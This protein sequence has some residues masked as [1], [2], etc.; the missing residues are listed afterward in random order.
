[1]TWAGRQVLVAGVGVTGTAVTRVLLDLGARVVVVDGGDGERQR[2]SAEQLRALGATVRLGDDRTLVDADLVVAT[3]GMRLDHPLF[4]AARAAGVEVVGEPELAWRL[5]GGGVEGAGAA[6][7]LGI[8]GTNGKTTTVGMLEA[9]LRAAGLR[10]VAAGNVGL[11]LVEAVHASTSSGEPS[12]DVLAV[13]MSSQQLAW[14]PSPRFAAGALLNIAEDHLDWHDTMADYLAAKTRIW[15]GGVAI[16]NA[17]DPVVVAALPAGGRTFSLTDH[18]A[19]YALVDGALV[20]TASGVV[21]VRGDE[22]R[23]R[24]PHNIANALAAAALARAHGVPADAVHDALAAFAPGRH[25]NE[26]V[27]TAGGVDY[28]DDSKATNPH[29]AAASLAAYDHVV[30][31]AGGLLKGADVDGLVA[32][33]AGRLRG[34]VLLGR[35]RAAIAAALA[36]HAPDVPVVDVT[37]TDTGAMETAVRRAAELARP[38]DTVLLAPTAASWDIFR[39]YAQRGDLFA[40]AARALAEPA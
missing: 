19:D 27:A 7:W 34:A 31:I 18:T 26:L 2:A 30:W 22:L 6:P 11:P 33:H 16:G 24:G 4:A 3:P 9:I 12:Y 17:D 32:A 39:D 14:S 23:V 38:G 29:A 8:T 36:R 13:E 1:V 15:S 10:T 35:D 5:R 20:E 21:L 25:R 40:A 37:A 28:V